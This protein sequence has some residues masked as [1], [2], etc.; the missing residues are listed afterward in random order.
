MNKQ[1]N[2]PSLTS[3]W[4]GP[5]RQIALLVLLLPL[6]G[7]APTSHANATAQ[8]AL[9]AQTNLIQVAAQHPDWTLS[10][11]VQKESSGDGVEQAAQRLGAHITKDLSI[12]NAFAADI[13]AGA[14]DQLAVTDGVRWVSLDGPVKQSSTLA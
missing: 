11:I 7:F 4:G 9:R 2:G 5:V 14:V 8:R 3:N 1:V 10:V 12:I 6:F 13:P